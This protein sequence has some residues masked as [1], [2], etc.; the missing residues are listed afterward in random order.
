MARHPRWLGSLRPALVA[1]TAAVFTAPGPA[2]AN[3]AFPDEF[4][5][6]F[7]PAPSPTIFI[8]AN[9]GML[10]SQDDGLTWRYACEPW[11]V[12]GSNA[13]LA[14]ANVS[15]YELTADGA[16]V[17][18]V[19]DIKAVTRSTDTA[20][21]WPNSS[22]SAIDGQKVSDLFPDPNNGSLVLA[23]VVASQNNL[24]NGN[25]IVASHDGGK[26]FEGPH[27][28]DTPAS[29][30]L[31]TGIEIARSKADVYYATLLSTT[32]GPAQFLASTNAGLTWTATSL[33]VASGTEARIMAVDPDDE[34]KVYL[35]AIGSALTDAILFTADGGQTFTNILSINGQFSSFLRAD[36]GALYAGTRA[37]KLY[38]R[39]AGATNP[40]DFTVQNAPHLRCLGQRRGT[41]RIYGC[42]DMLVDGY[43][44]A[45][46][47]DKAATFQPVMSLKDLQGPLACAAVQNNC[48]AHWQRIQC[49]LR[50]GIGADAG[51]TCG[52]AQPP[53][54]K[55]GGSSCSSAA[56]SASA[57]LVLLAYAWR[58][59]RWC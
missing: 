34:K 25:Y 21:T 44:L 15:Q 17:A 28:Y 19:F 11:V 26:T 3:N 31:L 12:A 56:G 9:F 54:A 23:T 52:A 49:V 32:G 53:P 50:I 7:P 1:L 41:S 35:R 6:H 2:R 10:V 18:A 33:N 51:Q 20:C 27:L 58:R 46:S 43:S 55:P 14:F 47:D 40:T 59:R 22:G 29:M 4:S 39:K 36:D 37:G 8:G 24:P 57:L 45:S 30:D 42:A 13:S 38:V 16:L 48:Q 5:I